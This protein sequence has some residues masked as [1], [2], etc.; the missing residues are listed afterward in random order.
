MTRRDLRS[1][2]NVWVRIGDLWIDGLAAEIEAGPTTAL[3]AAFAAKYQDW[4]NGS[5]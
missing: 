1:N 2:G 5:P 4:V 3:A